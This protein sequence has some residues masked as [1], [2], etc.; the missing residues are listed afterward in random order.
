MKNFARLIGLL[1]GLLMLANAHAQRPAPI[2]GT[3]PNSTQQQP[4]DSSRLEQRLDEIPDTVGVFYFLADNPNQETPFS[5]ST[6]ANFQ[7]YD[8]VRQRSLD[9]MHLGNL[10][11]AHQPIVFETT[12]RRGFDVGLHQFDLYM[13]PATQ[14]RF[15]RLQKLYECL[16]YG[17]FRASR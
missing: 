16:F 9:Y 5:D 4:F 1:T 11:S 2:P 13:T 6:L 7:Q 17:R 10:G 8:P 12:W 3:F 14:R 15:Y